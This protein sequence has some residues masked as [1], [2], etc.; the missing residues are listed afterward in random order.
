M[1]GTLQIALLEPQ[2]SCVVTLNKLIQFYTTFAVQENEKSEW[3]SCSPPVL[4]SLILCCMLKLIA[5]R[6]FQLP[7][8]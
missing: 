7:V 3:Q 8:P 4:D 1:H 6:V 2:D 5:V